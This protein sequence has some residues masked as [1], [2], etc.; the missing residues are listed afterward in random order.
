MSTTLAKM[1]DVA[2]ETVGMYFSDLI[3][4]GMFIEA[5]GQGSDF[6]WMVR[7]GGTDIV[8][9]SKLK[10]KVIRDMLELFMER[11]KRI[12]LLG[13]LDTEEEYFQELTDKDGEEK[14]EAY[15]LMDEIK[16][17]YGQIDRY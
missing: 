1:G 5:S 7:D 3:Q 10:I 12:F 13:R 6:L 11:N 4:D 14:T 2:K 9:L 16:K 17:A 8:D 15:I